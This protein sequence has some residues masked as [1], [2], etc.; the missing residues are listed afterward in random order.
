MSY[1]VALDKAWKRL[2]EDEAKK[3]TV[4][5]LADEYE[6]DLASQKVLS[7]SCNVP[8]HEHIT[9]LILH[10]LIQ[11][12]KGLPQ[13]TGEWISFKELPG[14]QA[15]FDAFKKRAL[16]PLICKYGKNP[17]GLSLCLERLPGKK[18][19]YGDIGIALEAFE[20]VPVLITLWGQDEEFSAE[21]NIL[22]DRSITEI[23][24]TEDVAVLSDI[25]SRLL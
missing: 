4:K 17:Q 18:I 7:L 23:F 10:Y 20:N 1:K 9:V 24:C 15:Y 14:G 13:V 8:P 16:D 25:I 12:L 21:A 11:K 3:F 22:F 19:Q 5:F 2:E 6:L